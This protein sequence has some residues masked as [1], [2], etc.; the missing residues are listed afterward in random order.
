MDSQV[1]SFFSRD[2]DS[3]IT[4]REVEVVRQFLDS[5]KVLT[6]TKFKHITIYV[7]NSNT[8]KYYTL[9]ALKADLFF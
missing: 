4:K 5:P 1:D 6:T 9:T 8:N 7:P 3:L 2:L